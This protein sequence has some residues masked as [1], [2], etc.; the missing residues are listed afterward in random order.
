MPILTF[1]RA[2]VHGIAG[3]LRHA[4]GAGHVAQGRCQQCRVVVFQH[5]SQVFG[6]FFFAVEVISNVESFQVGNLGQF[7]I[8]GK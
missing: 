1:R 7:E 3:Q 2:D 5:Y 8:N 6:N 4:T